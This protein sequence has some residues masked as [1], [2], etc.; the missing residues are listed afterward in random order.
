MHRVISWVQG[1]IP[2]LG[3]PG[4]F[5][6]AFLDSSFLSLP[7]IND[8]VVV[9]AAAT[10]PSGAWRFVL[11]A[12]LGSV[13]GCVVLWWLGRRG[14]EALLVRRFGADRVGR[15]RAAFERYELLALAIPAMLPPPMPFK[16]F[17]L[18]AGVFGVSL[19]RFALTIF[20]ARGLR[21]ALW[22]VFGAYYGDAALAMF[23]QVERWC[24]ERV[25]V[26]VFLAMAALLGWL[27][28]AAWRRWRP[29]SAA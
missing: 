27:V 3:L 19:R 11:M 14:G 24:G 9:T 16:L 2:L 18:S 21:Y 22:A 29:A 12:A 25:T 23:R 28:V 1:V 4:V 15:T 10:Q 13:A 8:L 17:V 5:L 20:V 26:L 6:A 7:E